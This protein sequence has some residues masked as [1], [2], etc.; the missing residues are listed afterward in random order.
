MDVAF[1]K[2][3]LHEIVISPV[4]DRG[5]EPNNRIRVIRIIKI[6]TTALYVYKNWGIIIE[7]HF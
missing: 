7:W 5:T 2:A 6:Y 3:V 1:L 4:C